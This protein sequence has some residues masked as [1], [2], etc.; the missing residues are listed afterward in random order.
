VSR[1]DVC[2]DCGG[3]LTDGHDDGRDLVEVWCDECG[4]EW[5]SAPGGWARLGSPE[6]DDQ[7]AAFRVRLPAP[8]PEAGNEG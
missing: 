8:D 6:A 2:P 5:A 4:E 7:Y 1:G 3:A